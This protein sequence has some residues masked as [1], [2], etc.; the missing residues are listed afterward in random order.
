MPPINEII[1]LL[2]NIASLIS[3]VTH[4]LKLAHGLWLWVKKL[5][6]KSK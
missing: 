6:R 2:K 1:E 3:A 5:L 4:L